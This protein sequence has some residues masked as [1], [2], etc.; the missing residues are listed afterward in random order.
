MVKRYKKRHHIL[1][2]LCLLDGYEL[3]TIISDT[4]NVDF[5]NAHKSLHL[6]L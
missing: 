4:I 1:Y 2:E 3:V 6:S 5:T